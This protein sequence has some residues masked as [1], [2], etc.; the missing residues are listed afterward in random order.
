MWGEALKVAAIGFSAV[1]V[2]LF[3]LSI[4]VRIMSWLCKRDEKKETEVEK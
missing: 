2:T 3:M 1:F 4:S